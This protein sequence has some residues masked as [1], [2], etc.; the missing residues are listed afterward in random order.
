MFKKNTNT[1]YSITYL[2]MFL[3]CNV[4]LSCTAGM[5]APSKGITH[6]FYRQEKIQG[7]VIYVNEYDFE[8]LN[9]NKG[10]YLF[11]YEFRS[12]RGNKI[13]GFDTEVK[14]GLRVWEHVFSEAEWDVKIKFEKF[15][16]WGHR[17]FITLLL[18]KGGYTITLQATFHKGRI[19]YGGRLIVD[20]S[21]YFKSGPSVEFH[22]DEDM[23]PWL[24]KYRNEIKNVKIDTVLMIAG[25]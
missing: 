3:S 16:V 7:E 14:S 20:M 5:Y 17:T 15:I 23:K 2:L 9:Q 19:V 18:T 4:L 21:T 10:L 1:K 25:Y 24:E 12:S 8:R 11:S 6:E 22:F 13:I